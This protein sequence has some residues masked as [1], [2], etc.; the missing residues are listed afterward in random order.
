MQDVIG[1]NFRRIGALPHIDRAP[2][3]KKKTAARMCASAQI[4]PCASVRL[5]VS[6]A[7]KL[8]LKANFGAAAKQIPANTSDAIVNFGG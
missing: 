5:A 2:Y 8:W 4:Q 1:A 7:H 3:R 6:I